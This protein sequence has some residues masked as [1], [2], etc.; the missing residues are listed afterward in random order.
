MSE[1]VSYTVGICCWVLWFALVY[2][3]KK[4]RRKYKVPRNNNCPD[5]KTRVETYIKSVGEWQE[6][7]VKLEGELSVFKRNSFHTI[8]D[9]QAQLIKE[10]ELRMLA[11]ETNFTIAKQRDALNEILKDK[12]K[13]ISAMDLALIQNGV[14]FD[15][16]KALK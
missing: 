5:C 3:E 11:A 16:H 12:Q 1:H 9:L 10:Q 2:Y 15:F 4:I 6:A 7:H 13:I 8:K 14:N